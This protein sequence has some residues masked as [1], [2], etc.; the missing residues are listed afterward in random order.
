M[1]TDFWQLGRARTG[2]ARGGHF[3]AGGANLVCSFVSGLCDITQAYAP[4]HVAGSVLAARLDDAGAGLA[5]GLADW[6][7]RAV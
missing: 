6:A 2:G 5:I 7:D 4:L 1:S 3:L